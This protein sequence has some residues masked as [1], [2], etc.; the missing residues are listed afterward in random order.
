MEEINSVGAVSGSE[1]AL[2]PAI[3]NQVEDKETSVDAAA[4]KS[5]R[6][7]RLVC[8]IAGILL[9]V[10]IGLV[11]TVVNLSQRINTLD[12][13]IVSLDQKT[14]NTIVEQQTQIDGLSQSIETVRDDMEAGFASQQE[15]ID[16]QKQIS[17]A[18]NKA[19]TRFQKQAEQ[20]N[21]ELREELK[22]D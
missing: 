18:T 12:Q 1:V 19:F 5:D 10:T 16:R 14:N 21:E 2:S 7:F 9:L 17:S 3:L 13:T 20:T 4:T 6:I 8:A 15:Q 11:A 22:K